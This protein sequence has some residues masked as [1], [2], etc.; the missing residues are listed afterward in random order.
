M[1]CHGMHRR[2]P[3]SVH[4]PDLCRPGPERCPTR[5]GG[6]KPPWSPTPAARWEVIRR[7]G[8]VIPPG[9]FPLFNLVFVACYQNLLLLM[10][11]LPMYVCWRHAGEPLNAVDAL[12][13]GAAAFFLTLEA[14]ADEQQWA[15]QVWCPGW[16]CLPMARSSAQAR[17][18]G[19]ATTQTRDVVP[20]SN[21]DA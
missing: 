15:F 14:A 13:A 21:A 16:D 2:R 7:G 8:S 6:S 17:K 9:A 10:I 11:M 18:V 3:A 1:P 4:A 20:G 5:R 12:A 19:W